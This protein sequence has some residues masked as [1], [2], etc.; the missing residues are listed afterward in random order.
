MPPVPLVRKNPIDARN[1]SDFFELFHCGHGL[2]LR[3]QANLV[4]VFFRTL[5]SRIVL[6]F[7][8]SIAL[9]SL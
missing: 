2:D 1:S 5:Y 6:P 7:N 8:A 3:D 9:A 4:A